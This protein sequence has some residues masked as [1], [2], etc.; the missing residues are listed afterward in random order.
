MRTL[1][2]KVKANKPEIHVHQYNGAFTTWSTYN[3]SRIGKRYANL[4]RAI[5]VGELLPLLCEYKA[6]GYQITITATHDRNGTDLR[7]FRNPLF[8]E[9]LES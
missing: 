7:P 6:K 2:P 8:L 3:V 4:K 5:F 9:D 1:N